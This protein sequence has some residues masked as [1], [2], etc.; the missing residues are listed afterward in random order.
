MKLEEA[1]N[2]IHKATLSMLRNGQSIENVI[3]LL[4]Q[5]IERLEAASDYVE[6]MNE[7]GFR[8]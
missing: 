7:S 1:F 2:S 5:E 3:Y 4:R 6:A 8:P